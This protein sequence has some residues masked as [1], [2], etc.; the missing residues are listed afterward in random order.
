MIVW[1]RWLPW[2]RLAMEIHGRD[3]NGAMVPASGTGAGDLSHPTFEL[4]QS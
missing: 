3:R 4:T 2:E 1:E